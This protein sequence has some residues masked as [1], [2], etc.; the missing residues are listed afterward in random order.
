MP[1]KLVQNPD[2]TPQKVGQRRT[3][4]KPAGEMVR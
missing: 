4:P 2:V 1:E 3:K